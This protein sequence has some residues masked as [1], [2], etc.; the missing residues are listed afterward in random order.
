MIAPNTM[1]DEIGITMVVRMYNI[2]IGVVLKGRLWTTQLNP[3]IERCDIVLAFLDNLKFHYTVP[4]PDISL[5][6][7]VDVSL[8]DE[9]G[10]EYDVPLVGKQPFLIDTHENPQETES[11]IS[12]LVFEGVDDFNEHLYTTDFDSDSETIVYN[13]ESENQ[14]VDNS[15]C[16]NLSFENT[17][18][19]N[20]VNT[21]CNKDCRGHEALDSDD[22]II[23]YS[24]TTPDDV[25]NV[26]QSVDPSNSDKITDG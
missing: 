1:L 25:S 16:D 6:L 4:A 20:D 14:A 3:D 10:N 24:F 13:F 9:Q 2:H 7:D 15:V 11:C 19:Q 8:C 17:D 26:E 5:K 22:S 12:S 18:C 21:C 23:L